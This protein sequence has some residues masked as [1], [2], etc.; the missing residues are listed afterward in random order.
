ML[1]H[2]TLSTSKP[3]AGGIFPS[4]PRS[5]S[6]LSSSSTNPIAFIPRSLTLSPQSSSSP[7]APLHPVL[8]LW[9]QEVLVAAAA[10]ASAQAIRQGDGS[11]GSS[12]ASITN[13]TTSSSC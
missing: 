12:I 4:L 9:T 3:S 2:K 13:I 10:A 6:Y 5:Q 7:F 1:S 11:F 8:L